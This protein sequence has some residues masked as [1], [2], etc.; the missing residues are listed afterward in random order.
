MKKY[1]FLAAAATLATCT[2]ETLVETPQLP[3]DEE[4]AIGFGTDMANMTRA[5]N[6]SGETKYAL[7]NYHNTFYV[8]GYKR[9]ELSDTEHVY[10]T[11]FNGIDDVVG[12]EE[13]SLVSWDTDW[14]Y[15]PARFWDKSAT[16]YNFYAAAPSQYDWEA[17]DN[18]GNAITDND[19]MKDEDDVKFSLKEFST[20]GLSL[21]QNTGTPTSSDK[22]LFA[23]DT[24]TNPDLMISND[25]LKHDKYTT[26]KVNFEFNHILSRLNIAVKKDEATLED[27]C[28]KITELKVYN[29]K[30]TGD[31]A[32]A[33]GSTGLTA[34]TLKAGTDLR[35]T[36]ADLDP[37]AL[38]VVGV[39]FANIS[40][41][42][43]PTTT[44]DAVVNT[45]TS[46]INEADVTAAT[47]IV[48]TSYNYM[49]QS[50]VIP[51]TVLF[52]SCKLN[53]TDV[54]AKD[55][56]TAK[57]ED[58]DAFIKV[59]YTIDGEPF[60]YFYNLA[61]VFS[62]VNAPIVDASGNSAVLLYG[63]AGYAFSTPTGLVLADG[64]P[65]TCFG[66]FKDGQ[67][68][69]SDMSAGLQPLY[70]DSTDNKFYTDETTHDD[71][72]LYPAQV[73]VM[74]NSDNTHRLAL[75]S[76]IQGECDVTFCEG[77]QNNLK[78]TI[79]PTAILFTGEVYEWVTKEENE[80]TVE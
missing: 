50:L 59:S 57:S 4:V 66:C 71:T 24:E 22:S 74:L 39:E 25:I 43:A 63:D 20:D 31:F 29:L 79:K 7:S 64:T 41:S 44:K 15:T 45:T 32:E 2:N 27:A 28:V 42:A 19:Y 80:H 68:Y 8:W 61:E 47:N 35:W 48:S 3:E 49:Y 46:Y 11:V 33:F 53:G 65:I 76:D 78:I 54:Y 36:K 70:I 6:S 62:N 77:W 72:T 18:D 37:D 73:F 40:S 51:Q 38:P 55:D 16:Y 69:Q 23:K 5:E 56:K 14:T 12:T 75:R 9:V 58:T 30:N 67:F 26:D 21:A 17:T 52:K 13:H 34:E 10:T 60:T 1:L